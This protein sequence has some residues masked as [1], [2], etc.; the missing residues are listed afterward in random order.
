MMILSF[1]LR[2]NLTWQALGDLLQLFNELR[3]MKVT[4]LPNSTYLFR[5]A[6]PPVDR[7]V[8]HFYCK[9]CVAYLGEESV[10]LVQFPSKDVKCNNCFY[11]FPMKSKN[12]AAFFLQLKIEPQL[13]RIVNK[14]SDYL[15]RSNDV[16]KNNYV[17]ISSGTYYK[18]VKEAVPNLISLTLN[19]DG[20]NI[21]NQR[22]D[23]PCGCKWLLMRF[24]RRN[25]SRRKMYLSRASGTVTILI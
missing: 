13:R 5:K 19:T 2:H 1:Y 23:H 12:K 24:L 4:K 6:L 11:E 10:L 9:R 20:V 15:C 7:F 8:T 21:L 22:K 17:D 25:D 18:S 14:F 16:D 3:S